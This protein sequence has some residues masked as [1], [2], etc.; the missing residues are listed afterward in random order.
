MVSRICFTRRQ[1]T[2]TTVLRV[3]L[4]YRRN[5]YA[6][7]HS[8]IVVDKLTR[9]RNEA[10]RALVCV[11]V[12]FLLLH[13]TDDFV[14]RN[15]QRQRHTVHTQPSAFLNSTNNCV[16]PAS[17][18]VTVKPNRRHEKYENTRT[19]TT[20]RTNGTTNKRCFGLKRITAPHK[21]WT[22]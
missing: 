6:L 2:T 17:S 16:Q 1:R 14:H 18:K 11:C 3:C 4:P 13:P 12:Y 15:Q 7:A 22:D 5:K 9:F 19:T 20:Q 21:V 10:S 8:R